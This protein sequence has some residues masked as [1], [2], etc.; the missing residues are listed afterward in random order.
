MV[1]FKN[2]GSV[3]NIGETIDFSEK[4]CGAYVNRKFHVLQRKT[5]EDKSEN[6][7]HQTRV[8]SCNINHERRQ[9][10]RKL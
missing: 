2:G 1:D 10:D 8:L 6:S 7:V 9:G 4:L 3:L 5:E